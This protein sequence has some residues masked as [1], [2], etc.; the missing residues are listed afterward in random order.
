MQSLVSVIVYG[1]A[2]TLWT[3]GAVGM[4]WLFGLL[5]LGGYG[6]AV[7]ALCYT[8]LTGVVG[9]YITRSS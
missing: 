4:S 7:G 2:V 6:T 5:P 8:A 9:W 3:L 1:I